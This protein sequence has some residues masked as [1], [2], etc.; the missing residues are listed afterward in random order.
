MTRATVLLSGG[1]DS[2]TCLAWAL[3][4]FDEVGAITFRYGQRHRREVSCA[5]EVAG[6]LDVRHHVVE[7]PQLGASALTDPSVAIT[8][9]RGGLPNTFVPA[10][11]AVFLSV[12][13]SLAFDG[14]RLDLV[15]GGSQ[16]D[17]S[18]YPDCRE[19]FRVA[20]GRA[21][22][23]ALGK[24]VVVHA[25]LMYQSKKAV[26]EMATSLDAVW[27]MSYTHTCYEGNIEPCGCCPACLLRAKGFEEAG[28]LDPLVSHIRD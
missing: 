21:L 27:L 18:G 10:R 5:E 28:V 20:M 9:G 3:R 2:T 25:P 16:A 24:Q 17:Y 1:Q 8:D 22:T 15:F 11:N 7:L 26:V 12:A 23:E 6:L 19:S 13:A 4:Q 14:R